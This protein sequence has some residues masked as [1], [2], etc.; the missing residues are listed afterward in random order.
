MSF[1]C[2]PCSEWTSWAVEGS[3]EKPLMADMYSCCAPKN[4]LL[5]LFCFFQHISH[6]LLTY[7]RRAPDWPLRPLPPRR[8]PKTMLMQ[9]DPAAE[10]N[11]RWSTTPRQKQ[12]SVFSKNWSCKSSPSLQTVMSFA[13]D[14]SIWL[15]KSIHLIIVTPLLLVVR[16]GCCT[17]VKLRANR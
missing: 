1:F 16:R 6:A 9:E 14:R 12:K 8:P 3:Q 13:S 7:N 2:F 5:F 17:T 15:E 4:Q 10:R 11:S